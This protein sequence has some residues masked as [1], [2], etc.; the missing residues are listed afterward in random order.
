MINRIAVVRWGVAVFAITH[1]LISV[2]Q[3]NNNSNEQ[4][5]QP[6]FLDEK[7]SY[8]VNDADIESGSVFIFELGNAD[9]TAAS[10]V[11]I[12]ADNQR[13]AALKVLGETRDYPIGMADVVDDIELRVVEGQITLSRTFIQQEVQSQSQVPNID[14]LEV[15]SIELTEQWKT[16]FPI[17][18]YME[19]ILLTSAYQ[20]VS[21]ASD[22]ATTDLIRDSGVI[23][24]RQD[25]AGN[26]QLRV[27][28]WPG[29]PNFHANIDYLIIEAQ[30][31]Q[32]ETLQL[33][34]A[35]FNK[36]SHDFW[37]Q[38]SFSDASQLGMNWHHIPSVVAQPQTQSDERSLFTRIKQ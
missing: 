21:E 1:T 10:Y 14:M 8:F 37:Q 12:Y 15:G 16:L 9:E 30:E 20:V 13:I 26:W 31:Y 6:L 17:R 24:R 28:P 36:S 29:M 25:A 2:V 5:T 23:E 27:R 7:Q 35:R 4:L 22:G 3:A 19:P 38:W 34:A 18:Q 33:L 11:D 32:S